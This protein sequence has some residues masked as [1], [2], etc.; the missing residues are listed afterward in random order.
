MAKT[1]EIIE[2][3]FPSG[4]LASHALVAGDPQSPAVV[5]LH[6]AGPGAHAASN[7]RPIIPDL[8]ENFFVVAPDL[9]G[10]GQSEY[11]E[12][13]P[14]HIM[15]WVGMRVEQILGLM[16]H[17][18]IEKSHIVGNSMGG[19]VTLQLVVEAPERFDKVAL[20]GSVGAPMN[21]RPPELA[22]LLAFYADPRLTPYRELI[23]SFVYDPENF[24]GMEEIVKSR[25][26]VANDPEVRRIQEVMF[27]SMKAGMESLVIPPAT[28]GRLPHDVLVFHGRQ[29]RI[30]PLDT[31]L[32]LTKHLKHAELVVLDRCGHW[33]QLER[34][35]AMGPMLMEHF[36]A[37]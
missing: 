4:T 18:G 20:M 35:D 34:W 10:F 23:H 30:V 22:R 16:N 13:Y 36:R 8:A 1:V 7:W 14:G 28:L 9:I 3:R 29:D 31:S 6:G 17:F 26:E 37:A 12:T 11:P 15:S 33:A 27:E 24:P 21:A 25:F 19:A 32:Y 2:K 5:L